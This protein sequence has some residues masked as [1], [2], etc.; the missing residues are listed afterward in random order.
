MEDKNKVQLTPGDADPQTMRVSIDLGDESGLGLTWLRDDGLWTGVAVPLPKG[1]RDMIK[2]LRGP[3][4]EGGHC[5]WIGLVRPD[6]G[7]PL[8]E[9][10]AEPII[11]V[12]HVIDQVDIDANTFHLTN[13]STY[14]IPKGKAGQFYCGRA[15]TLV[16]EDLEG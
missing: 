3:D 1:V 13:G 15:V 6:V 10:K 16:I 4:D 11:I 12:A 5:P 8:P 9:W 14:S 7:R 2:G